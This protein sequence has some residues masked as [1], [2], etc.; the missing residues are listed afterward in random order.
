MAI[1][2]LYPH[3]VG[4]RNESRCIQGRVGERQCAN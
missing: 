2:F 1:D 3:I 4:G